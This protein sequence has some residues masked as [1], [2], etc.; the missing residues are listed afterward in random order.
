MKKFN[1]MGVAAAFL[2]A[3]FLCAASIL[4]AEELRV[5][6]VFVPTENA[7][8]KIAEDL[9]RIK[10]EKIADVSLAL[11]NLVPEGVPAADKFAALKPRF[12]KIRECAK[13]AEVGILIQSS[14]GHSYPLKNPNDMEHIV[15]F[16][17]LKEEPNKCCPLGEK[18][19]KYM[20]DIC[21]RA[22]ALKPAH[23][24][25]DDDFRM[26]TG[27]AQAGCLC[28]LHLRQISARLGRDISAKEAKAAVMGASAED[29]RTA[30]II[31][32]VI[33][34]SI[35][36]LAEK[37]RAAI[38]EVDPKIPASVCVCSNDI[39]YAERLGKAFAAKGQTPIIRIN[40]ARYGAFAVSPNN[41]AITMYATACQLDAL[42]GKAHVIAETDCL[43][44]NRFGTSANELHTNYTAFLFA[45][46]MGAKQWI[47]VTS[48]FEAGGNEAYRKILAEHAGFY[49]TLARET[50]NAKPKNELSTPVPVPR[51]VMNPFAPFPYFGAQSWANTF[52]WN[53][54]FP[55]NFARAGTSPAFLSA[56][57]A[58]LLSDAE[59][60]AV[61]K[62]GAALD[63]G[64][65]VAL[66]KRGFAKYI[67]VE[68]SFYPP[69]NA[70]C[71]EFVSDDAFN[72][73]LAGKRLSGGSQFA[74]LKPV[75]KSVRVLANFAFMKFAQDDAKNA[76]ILSPSCTLFENE[77]GARVAVVASQP[78]TGLQ[79]FKRY[80][81]KELLARVFDAVAPFGMR[82][83][84]DAKV[85]VQSA[86]L[87]DGTELAAIHNF[88][89]DALPTFSLKM[90]SRPN[91][92]LSLARDGGWRRVDFKA[93]A[94]DGGT[95]A[96][97]IQR[98][99]E[100]MRPLVL[101]FFK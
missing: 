83:A 41:F 29:R 84:G 52:L 39:A 88:G 73:D 16:D 91:K 51:S 60:T 55:V 64:A 15:R 19:G 86:A 54:G 10:R 46:C 44:H 63:S 61:L 1:L 80:P 101:K 62:R 40:N 34:D 81:R 17:T 92:I 59:L 79:T 26:Y 76:E 7:E 68:A 5:F 22:A 9:L 36:K 47:S 96:V 70:V 2:C 23:I 31:D 66:T 77:F 71:A 90:R 89:F 67:G 69:V 30:K 4:S 94:S 65:A 14:L 53:T 48:E 37:M 42:K 27:A 100:P 78:D 87:S 32:E 98:K 35:C 12:E 56:Q 72:G 50:D 8:E 95:F 33:V 58:R 24:M 11:F 74:L 57:D 13:G 85:Y 25:I 82:Y 3:A 99:L 97:E 75:S 28:P 93:E 18:V 20:A 6:N 21:R 49:A 43:P 45:G 38:D